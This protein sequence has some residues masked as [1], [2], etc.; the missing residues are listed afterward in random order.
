M[1]RMSLRLRL[2]L[3]T[4]ALVAAL[5]AALGWAMVVI[6]EKTL[7]DAI[8]RELLANASFLGQRGPRPPG[9][10][11][12]PPMAPNREPRQ[13]RPG[14]GPGP[15]RSPPVDPV[16]GGR[17][18]V[19]PVAD[20]PRFDGLPRES[21]D[22]IGY[23]IAAAGKLVFRTTKVEGRPTR[24]VSL[25]LREQGRVV[26]VV[27]TPRGIGDVLDSS[28]R[29][30]AILTRVVIPI[31]AVVAGLASL[32][33]V[34]GFMRPLRKITQEIERIESTNLSRRLDST[35]GDE[36]A[37]LSTTLN[38]MLARVQRGFEIEKE[39]ADAQRRFAA[40]ASHELRTP[41][42]TVKT[43]AGILLHMSK[44]SAED[45]KAAAAID[46]A[47]DQ[48]N[49]L[50]QDLLLLAKSEAPAGSDA[51]EVDLGES[52]RDVVEL[53]GQDRID[54]REPSSPVMVRGSKANLSRVWQNLVE[55]ALRHSDGESR[56]EIRVGVQGQI[57]EIVVEDHGEGVSAEHL[58]H[59]FERFYRVDSSRS[60][61]SGGTG[62][63]LS[64][65]QSL[66]QSMGGSIR[67][68]SR[69]GEGTRFHVRLPI[70][71]H[72]GPSSK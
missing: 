21:Y 55:N 28:N 33:L 16:F 31:G 56:V 13:G 57:A 70:A 27:Q 18:R 39:A 44:L 7:F 17:P 6:A 24:V 68:E 37:H 1:S 67:V 14:L 72:N 29:L 71:S 34:G 51:P 69:V 66:V 3:A 42:A 61:E 36:F 43:N 23:E 65:C 53:I 49:R 12:G 62:L 60:S 30:K 58:P 50:V 22:S 48:M 41:L 5:L 54:V 19:I 45:R 64:I 15:F 20:D 9:E 8:D 52:V 11:G 47:T 35:G 40:D 32:L 2:T 38:R 46:A 10:P 25:P 26:A 59:L 4:V 63:G